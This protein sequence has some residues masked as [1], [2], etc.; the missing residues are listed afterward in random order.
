MLGRIDPQKK[1]V[2]IIGAGISGLLLAWDLDRRGYEVTLIE[3][4]ARAGGL[5]HSEWTE[6]GLSENA[7]HSFL[8]SPRVQALCRDL[9]VALVPVNP[10][11]RARYIWRG[12]RLRRFPLRVSRCVAA[13]QRVDLRR[14]LSEAPRLYCHL[15][16][17]ASETQRP[18]EL[19]LHQRRVESKISSQTQRL[20]TDHPL[21]LMREHRG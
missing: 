6:H 15:V 13:H 4:G 18:C 7:A 5:I 10:E 9:D 21:R 11:S 3:A 20:R 8:A 14:I 12:G 17:H 1:K 19:H 2:T 16:H